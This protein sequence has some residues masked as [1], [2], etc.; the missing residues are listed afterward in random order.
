MSCGQGIKK[1]KVTCATSVSN[2]NC[3]PQAIPMSWIYCN[4][5]VCP[6]TTVRPTQT[7]I[8]SW[9]NPRS[10]YRK[11]E[12]DLKIEEHKW[13]VSDWSKVRIEIEYEMVNWR[14]GSF[15]LRDAERW[16]DVFFLISTICF[17]V[18]M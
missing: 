1:R 13:T 15:V 17:H 11:K 8:G 6:K 18:L 14:S 10:D 7:T 16:G 2:E 3:D 5:G 9:F 12:L 4:I